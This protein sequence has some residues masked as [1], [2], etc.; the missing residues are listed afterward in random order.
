MYSHLVRDNTSGIE[1]KD[2]AQSR[3]YVKPRTVI[4]PKNSLLKNYLS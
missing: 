3:V 2:S 4:S 1:G